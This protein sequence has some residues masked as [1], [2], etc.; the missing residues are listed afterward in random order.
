MGENKVEKTCSS[1]LRMLAN[2]NVLVFPGFVVAVITPFI[3]ANFVSLPIERLSSKVN[4][5]VLE[6]LFDESAPE[7]TKKTR[8]A[9]NSMD[10]KG[11]KSDKIDPE[12]DETY[13]E[14][15]GED[16]QYDEDVGGY[17]YDQHYDYD[18]Y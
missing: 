16:V 3:L 4:Y 11:V 17:G 10:D 15:F 6:K 5:D 8:T 13:E 9:Y 2:E 1:I 18:D 7:N 12:V 14:A